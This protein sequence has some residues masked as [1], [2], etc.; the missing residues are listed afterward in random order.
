MGDEHF[1]RNPRFFGVTPQCSVCSRIGC[2]KGQHIPGSPLP[3]MSKGVKSK[4]REY[5]A[6]REVGHR[7]Q[8][9]A[10]GR[11]GANGGC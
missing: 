1:P 2:G 11:N 10:S 5:A 3:G 8:R 6:R 9:K 7:S 4:Q